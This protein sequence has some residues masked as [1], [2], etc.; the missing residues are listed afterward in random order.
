MRLLWLLT[1]ILLTTLTVAAQEEAPPLAYLIRE[2]S[3][4]IDFV[5]VWADGRRESRYAG[6]LPGEFGFRRGVSWESV[7]MVRFGVDFAI[8][9]YALS[10]D[11]TQLAFSAYDPNDVT[12]SDGNLYR[13]YDYGLFIYSFA[14]SRPGKPSIRRIDIDHPV[15][16]IWSPEGDALLLPA[17]GI[18]G[19]PT[20][21]YGSEPDT[22]IYDLKTQQF[23]TLQ[24]GDPP[25]FY[26]DGYD[27]DFDTEGKKYY[28]SASAPFVWL[29]D[30][31]IG[32]KSGGIDCANN[33]ESWQDLYVA[34]RDGS[35]VQRLT[36]LAD[37]IPSGIGMYIEGAAW[38]P[39]NER[40]YY[41]VAG[42]EPGIDSAV[43]SLDL[44]GRGGSLLARAGSDAGLLPVAAH[45]ADGAIYVTFYLRDDHWAIWHLNNP[46]EGL[47]A[48]FVS[49]VTDAGL[50]PD[51]VSALPLTDAY[52]QDG[53]YAAI[54]LLI[55]NTNQAVTVIVD[56]T[57]GKI[58]RKFQTGFVCGLRWLDG[59]HFR[60][61]TV[62]DTLKAKPSCPDE[63]D[64]LWL[65]DVEN[66]SPL[67]LTERESQP[68]RLLPP[69]R[70][71]LQ[72]SF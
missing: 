66:R 55:K 39:V 17:V 35:N 4:Q 60:F 59:S 6:Y 5:A 62:G 19:L 31:R 34:N 56:L 58:V 3:A 65:A 54:N 45:S 71:A 40:L 14:E 7:G 49:N 38:S 16:V 24:A 51:E 63:T 72:T 15:D 10:P 9:D 64:G 26:T 48:A 53:H 43:Y 2:N 1:C 11:Q 67:D 37:D 28:F 8:G 20:P 61:Q 68:M 12:G 18:E 27:G 46:S 50:T 41:K 30:N 36:H 23:Y 29:P 32:F 52:S 47:A 22:L 57:A 33:C 21:F 70:G 42:R 13:G 69:D 44:N 25:V